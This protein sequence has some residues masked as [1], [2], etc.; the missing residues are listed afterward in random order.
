L[1]LSAVLVAANSREFENGWRER[2]RA[3][4]VIIAEIKNGN[5]SADAAAYLFVPPH[6]FAAIISRFRELHL[7]PFRGT[8]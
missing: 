6:I 5:A 3:M 8:N 7:G 1:V 2:N 4:G